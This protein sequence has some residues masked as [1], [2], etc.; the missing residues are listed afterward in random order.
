MLGPAPLQKI[1]VL[2]DRIGCSCVPSLPSPHL[3]RHRGDIVANLRIEDRPAIPQ[4]F[5]KR[6]RFILGEDQYSAKTGVQAVGKGK[7]NNPVNSPE[8]NCRLGSIGSQ[9]VKA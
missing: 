7:I 3:G 5:L 2:L 6:V 8:G 4:M 1:T 9:R